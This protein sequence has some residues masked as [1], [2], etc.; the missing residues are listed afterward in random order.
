M[1]SYTPFSKEYRDIMPQTPRQ[2]RNLSADDYRDI[3]RACDRA[4]S[5]LQQDDALIVDTETTDLNGEIIQIA[6]LDMRG[7]VVLDTLV[8]PQSPVTSGAFAVHHISNSRLRAESDWTRIAPR[9]ASLAV[10]RLLVSYNAPFDQSMVRNSYAAVR[11]VP[12]P[13]RWECAM[14]LYAQYLH[15]PSPYGGYRWVSLP[16]GDHSALGDTRAT[17]DILVA[18]AADRDR[19]KHIVQHLQA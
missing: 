12:I 13:L 9:F 15:E 14:R 18:M 5:L 1:L 19:I 3:L 17:L 4:A 8:R 6:M 7:Q 10:N 11:L 2:W 16:G